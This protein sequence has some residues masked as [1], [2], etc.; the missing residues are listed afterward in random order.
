MFSRH[1]FSIKKQ[2]R[3]SIQLTSTPETA[4]VGTQSS[5]SVCPYLPK[6]GT[7]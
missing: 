2:V 7:R 6:Y 4:K 5:K 3:K 1:H